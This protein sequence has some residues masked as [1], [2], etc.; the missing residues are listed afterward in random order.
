[1]K[2][3]NKI[4][5]LLEEIKKLDDIRRKNED[6][7][8]EDEMKLYPPATPAAVKKLLNG[9]W[10]HPLPGSFGEFLAASDGITK[11][12][13]QLDFLTTDD[14]RQ[15]PIR[16]TV[17]D[18]IKQDKINLRAMFK[19]VDQALIEKWESD[20]E[21]FYVANHA[22]I[23][24]S[25]T[26]ALLFYDSRTRDAKGEMQLCWRSAWEATIEQRYGNIQEYLEAALEEAR[27]DAGGE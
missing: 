5:S 12:R 11:F 7:S 23:A 16:E 10:T 24:V 27:A 21:N 26:G 13:G 15:K 6:D 25:E 20:P 17:K 18:K 14:D 3:T 22:V 1:L 8:P 4:R 9:G 2:T 19:T